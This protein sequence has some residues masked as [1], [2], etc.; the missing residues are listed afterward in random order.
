MYWYALNYVDGSFVKIK[1]I[2]LS[3]SLPKSVTNNL[4][5]SNVK[6]YATAKNYF[7][8][9]KVKNFD[10]EAGGSMAFPLAKQIIFGVNVNL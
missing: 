3:Y 7:V 5:L 4:R 6:L 2:T 10:P 1:D 9:S 8:F